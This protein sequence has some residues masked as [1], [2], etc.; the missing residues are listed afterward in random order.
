MKL[1]DHQTK[2]IERFRELSVPDHPSFAGGTA[3]YLRGERGSC[4]IITK[5]FST[6]E[7]RELVDRHLGV[8]EGVDF[9][10]TLRPMTYV[11]PLIGKQISDPSMLRGLRGN[12]SGQNLSA[13]IGRADINHHLVSSSGNDWVG[14]MSSLTEKVLAKKFGRGS[15]GVRINGSGRNYFDSR[16][17]IAA[18]LPELASLEFPSYD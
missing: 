9:S 12:F 2:Y 11:I 16:K 14:N 4:Y 13:V 15:F 17:V 18:F 7:L 3:D 8:P 10:T 6:D 5:N 1:N